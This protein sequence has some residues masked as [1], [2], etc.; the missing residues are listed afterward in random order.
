MESFFTDPGDI[1]ET[2]ILTRC[3][4]LVQISWRLA[5]LL[6]FAEKY[7]SLYTLIGKSMHA[8]VI[9]VFIRHKNQ[10]DALIEFAHI[11]MDL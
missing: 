5:S 3:L 9:A 4:N 8:K 10:L 7:R 1:L 11:V 6:P 2:L